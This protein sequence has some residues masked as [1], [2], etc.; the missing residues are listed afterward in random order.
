VLATRA[1]R[2][3]A[4]AYVVLVA[5]SL[6]L[7]V[8][9]ATP[10][11][12]DLRRGVGF[13]LTPI[14]AALAGTTRGLGSVLGAL[15]EIDR[16]RQEND[17][18]QTRNQQLEQQDRA[19]Q[20]LRIQN[21]QLTALL[22]VRSVLTYHTT[23][24]AVVGRG[25]SL[26]ERVM[27][28]DRGSDKGIQVGDI[29]VAVGAALV[30]RVYEVGPDYSRVLLIS[31]TRMNVVGMTEQTRATGQVQGQLG[32][33]LAMTQIP[34]TDTVQVGDDVVTAGIDLGDGIRSPYPKGLLIGRVVDV[35][36]DPSAV[37]QTALV[38]PAAPLDQLEYVLVITDYQGGLPGAP[39]PSP[40]PSK[41]PS[42]TP[43][44]S[45]PLVLPSPSLGAGP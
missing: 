41:S 39:S 43:G 2:R 37:V 13:A 10:P 31:D 44:G 4:I 29:V 24:A 9:D 21:Q 3:R 42:T 7:L 20:E 8:L 5:I 19:D 23:A 36:K 1:A 28:L 40:S 15:G 35:Q 16:L 32:G 6:S 25:I 30:G 33:N 38:E 27:T 11:L 22:D 17:Q 26:T 14:Q 12:Q 45:L 34:S 18:L